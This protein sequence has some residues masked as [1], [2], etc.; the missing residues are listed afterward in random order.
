[1]RRG[2]TVIAAVDPGWR[3]V[4][5]RALGHPHEACRAA[6]EMLGPNAVSAGSLNRRDYC[7]STLA[8]RS[9]TTDDQR[10]QVREVSRPLKRDSSAHVREQ[11]DKAKAMGAIAL[12][13]EYPTEVRVVSGPF[14][15]GAM[16]RHPCEQLRRRSVRDDPGRVVDRLGVRRVE[17]YV[18]LDSFRHLAKERALMASW[19]R[20]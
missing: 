9:V 8:W 4:P 6:T 13:G 18:G 7:A 3:R 14:S 2:D 10:T 16:W 15:A 11:L 20:H 17:A 12:F 1:M 5:R 19:P